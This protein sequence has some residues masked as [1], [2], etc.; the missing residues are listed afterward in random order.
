MRRCFILGPILALALLAGDVFGDQL[1]HRRKHHRSAPASHWTANGATLDPL[2]SNL[3]FYFPLEE[4]SG[5]RVDQVSSFAMTVSDDQGRVTGK[6]N[7]G[8]KGGGT[9]LTLP[10][11][12]YDTAAAQTSSFTVWV[13]FKT[14]GT[15]QALIYDCS[16]TAWGGT[17]SGGLAIW[18]RNDSGN[19]INAR[20]YSS[21]GS[22]IANVVSASA[23]NDGNW[24]FVCVVYTGGG[25]PDLK[26][27]TDAA[28]ANTTPSA[29]IGDN[30]NAAYLGSSAD[31]G[32]DWD[33]SL[34][35]FGFRN[36]NLTA[37]QV[38]ALYNSGTGAFRTP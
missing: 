30:G 34:D 4:A 9:K 20:M 5:D 33:G 35:E 24:H 27:Y 12:T 22:T 14:T 37:D 3:M 28:S 36:T 31:G 7:Y 23:Y 2:E 32:S 21:T 19:V 16:G 11:A 8:L 26:L 17:G 15:S 10:H 1:I 18:R 6:Y 38:S 13:W 29:A 25:S